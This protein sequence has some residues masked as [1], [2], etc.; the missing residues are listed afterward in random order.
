MKPTTIQPTRAETLDEM[1][2]PQSVP[3]SVS[4]DDWNLARRIHR[5]MLPQRVEDRRVDIAVLYQ[6][7]EIIGGD[8]CSIVMKDENRL[9]LCMCDVTGHGMPA[10]ILAGRI[11]SFVRQE[12]TI[13]V[14]PCEVVSAL[15]RFMT[16][17]FGSLGVSASFY[18][19]EVNLRWRGLTHAGAGHPPALLLQQNGT[20]DRLESLSPLIGAF[21]EMAQQCQLTKNVYTAGDRLLIYTDGL[22]ETRNAAGDFFGIDR[23]ESVLRALDPACD[24]EGLLSTLESARRKFSGRELPDDDVLVM[25]IQFS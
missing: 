10:A 19:V 25:A 16:E 24:S 11:N 2:N 23:V 22:T 18:C 1:P 15:N 3:P 4:I 14:Q 13:A 8:Y 9:V 6:E 21:P 17:H 7:H 5:S 12:I 20:I